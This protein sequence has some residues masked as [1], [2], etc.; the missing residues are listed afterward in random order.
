[1]SQEK[2]L[3]DLPPSTHSFSLDVEGN[4]TKKKFK[5]EFSCK[6][7]NIK[8][9]VLISKHKAFLNGDMADFLDPGALRMNHMISYLRFTLTEFPTWWKDSD[10]GYDLFDP[11]VVEEVY[12]NVLKFEESWTKEVWGEKEE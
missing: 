11:N 10:M 1:M 9:N 5:G 3:K 12:D 4:V 8:T 6:I 7:T 2:L